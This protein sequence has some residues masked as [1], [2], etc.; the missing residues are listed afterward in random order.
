MHL[1]L[2]IEKL[3]SFKNTWHYIRQRALWENIGMCRCVTSFDRAQGLLF[4]TVALESWRMLNFFPEHEFSMMLTGS[5]L[6]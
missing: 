3:I 2:L 4:V 5:G 6:L 1:N